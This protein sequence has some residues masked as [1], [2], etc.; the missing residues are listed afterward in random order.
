MPLMTGVAM[1]EPAKENKKSGCLMAGVS[2]VFGFL[3]GG[4]AAFG[5]LDVL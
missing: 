4:V 2:F 1:S 5:I 3:L